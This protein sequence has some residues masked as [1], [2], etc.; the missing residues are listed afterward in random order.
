[1]MMASVSQ[2]H[3]Y[4]VVKCFVL[5]VTGPVYFLFDGCAPVAI[6]AAAAALT[7]FYF[8]LWQ[9]QTETLTTHSIGNGRS[10]AL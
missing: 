10:L 3:L 7:H 4:S 8:V 9:C 2:Q 6:V 5:V 1:M